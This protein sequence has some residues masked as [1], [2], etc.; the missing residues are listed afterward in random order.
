MIEWHDVENY[1]GLFSISNDGRVKDSYGEELKQHA[2]NGYMYVALK[3]LG[4]KTKHIAVHRLV[5]KAFVEN[6]NHNPIVNHIDGNKM[7]NSDYNLEWVTAKENSRHSI[8]RDGS[9]RYRHTI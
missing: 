8:R 7:H 6:A 4:R 2:S 3:A 1:E 5:A 9:F